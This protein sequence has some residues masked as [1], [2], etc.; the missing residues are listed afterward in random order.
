MNLKKLETY[1]HTLRFMKWQQIRYRAFYTIRNRYRKKRGFQYPLTS[2]ASST[3]LSLKPSIVSQQ[4][5]A[6]SDGTHT[7]AFLNLE[8]TFKEKIDWN[9]QEHGKLWTYNLNY[10]DYLLQPDMTEEQ[11]LKLITM[12]IDDIGQ[13]QDGLEPFPIALRG[14]NWIKFLTYYCIQKSEIDNSLFAQY[15]ILMDNLEYHLLGNHLLENG[16]SLLFGAFYF[17]DKRLFAKAKEI[18]TAELEEQILADGAHFE[19]SPMYHQIMLYRV[20]DCYNLMKHN[21]VFEDAPLQMLLETKASLMLGWLE[22]MTYANGAVPLFNDT[23]EGIAPTSSQLFEYGNR[24]GIEVKRLPLKESGYRKFQTQKYELVVDVGNIGPDYIP[25]HAH[26]DTFNFELHIAKKP[27]IVDTGISTYESNAQRAYERSTAA[28]NTVLVDNREQS[29]VWSSFR[30]A[31][32]AKIVDLSE[33]EHGVI[34]THD[35]YAPA[36][37]LH[38]REVMSH[39]SRIEIKDILDFDFD[40]AYEAVALLHFAPEIAV[41]LVNDNTIMTKEAL[42]TF[43]GLK[44]LEIVDIVIAKGYNKLLPAKGVRLCFQ[45]ELTTHIEVVSK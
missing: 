28:H 21:A 7:F 5:Y 34:A 16:F 13:C 9:F 24:V 22:N 39:P 30:V 38:T 29:E 40:K 6:G 18:L 20:L 2:E 10:F 3:T 31:R 11:G 4:S 14:I 37:V 45:K 23:A 33:Y 12:F 15:D 41:S 26:S 25:G 42:F 36:G 17:A 1:F 44:R 8:H 27:F 35:G 32:R 19:L 43:E